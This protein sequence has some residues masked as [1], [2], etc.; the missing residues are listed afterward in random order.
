M[1]P[2]NTFWPQDWIFLLVVLVY[3]MF[4]LVFHK[5][6]MFEICSL[7]VHLMSLH[8]SQTCTKHNAYCTIKFRHAKFFFEVVRFSDKLQRYLKNFMFIVYKLRTCFTWLLKIPTNHISQ[9]K[10]GSKFYKIVIKIFIHWH[11][12]LILNKT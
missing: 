3:H 11:R 2:Y 5:W 9:I 8:L 6:C 10:C 12:S 4:S 7:F 1:A